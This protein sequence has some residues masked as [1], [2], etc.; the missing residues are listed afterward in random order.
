M[1]SPSGRVYAGGSGSG[2]RGEAACR[3][4]V[5]RNVVSRITFGRGMGL[6]DECCRT[7]GNDHPTKD[8]PEGES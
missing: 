7:C 1:R 4:S 2:T 5:V 6:R 8:H 3:P